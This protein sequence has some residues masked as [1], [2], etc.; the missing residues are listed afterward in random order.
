MRS[1]WAA[2]GGQ[3]RTVRERAPTGLQRRLNYRAQWV[4]SNAIELYR[5]VGLRIL[6]PMEIV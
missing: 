4:S 3:Q 1:C 5:Q 6:G 2:A